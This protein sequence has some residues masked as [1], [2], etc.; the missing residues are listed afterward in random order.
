M[1]QKPN[2]FGSS[3]N[4][5]LKPI[6]WPVVCGVVATVVAMGSLLFFLARRSHTKS[7]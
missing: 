7:S 6:N 4:T 3:C 1:G 2:R 5:W